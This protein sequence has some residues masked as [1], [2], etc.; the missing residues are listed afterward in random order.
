MVL[1]YGK[2]GEFKG[3][4]E[5]IAAAERL[6]NQGL[7]FCL[8][9]VTGQSGP[10]FEGLLRDVENRNLTERFI[11]VPYLPPWRVPEILARASVVAFLENRFPITI[12]RPQIPR[13]A[14]SA[15]K[16]VILTKDV[17]EYQRT[18]EP[19]IDRENVLLVSDPREI[20]QLAEALVAALDP[21]IG[22]AIAEKSRSVYSLPSDDTGKRWIDRL[23]GAVHVDYQE[24]ETRRMAIDGFN[25][26]LVRL[27]SD[28]EYRLTMRRNGEIPEVAREQL[29]QH[30]GRSLIELSMDEEA[31]E[32]Y[33]RSILT[34]K[35]HFLSRPFEVLFAQY[36]ELGDSSRSRFLEQWVLDDAGLPSDFGRFKALVLSCLD[37]NGPDGEQ[38]GLIRDQVLLVGTRS[39]VL[40]SEP[41]PDSDAADFA[42]A[43]LLGLT[44]PHRFLRLSRHPH[45]TSVRPWYVL[46]E[47]DARSFRTNILELTLSTAALFEALT[48]GPI[49]VAEAI[50]LMIDVSNAPEDEVRSAAERA[51]LD[52]HDR[53]LVTS[54]PRT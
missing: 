11:A 1:V 29:T 52:Y 33:C 24:K 4:T 23:I 30:E 53:G 8:L 40:Y 20:D 43:G 16:C 50:D 35:Y 5:L 19:L 42:P 3:T 47:R 10:W 49:P 21:D 54:R 6:Q 17:A 9:F 31:L 13:E 46:I 15:G 51:I 22:G 7:D 48:Q 45:L 27:Y 28:R 39:E 26:A 41:T 38:A 32:R 14:M 2:L 44:A 37:S 12:H 36:S 25:R 34:K 18:T